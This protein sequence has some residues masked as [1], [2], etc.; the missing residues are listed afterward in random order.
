MKMFLKNKEV[1]KGREDLTDSIHQKL[2][3]FAGPSAHKV[4]EKTQF[5]LSVRAIKSITSK[6]FDPFRNLIK[7]ND[8]PETED[9][10]ATHSAFRV[11]SNISIL[12]SL[13]FLANQV[14]EKINPIY[15]SHKPKV[16]HRKNE[17]KVNSV[18]GSVINH[19]QLHIPL[20]DFDAE[21]EPLFTHP[22]GKRTFSRMEDEE[23]ALKQIAAN[24]VGA[25]SFLLKPF[26][27]IS[28]P[29]QSL[30]PLLRVAY[31]SRDTT[32]KFNPIRNATFTGEYYTTIE[33]LVSRSM[34]PVDEEGFPLYNFDLS[35]LKK[36]LGIDTEN[37]YKRFSDLAYQQ[38]E[39]KQRELIKERG[40]ALGEGD[41]IES[42]GFI[43]EAI[44]D[45]LREFSKEVVGL[46]DA[47]EA[48]S[49]F[50]SD[51]SSKILRQSVTGSVF[52]QLNI[53]TPFLFGAANIKMHNIDERRA[54]EQQLIKSKP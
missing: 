47:I 29:K 19:M 12:P 40:P 51:L 23:F 8:I 30:R 52:S 21:L 45:G 41:V 37:I 15:I 49:A 32:S 17:D 4:M 2:D 20:P 27:S 50:T 28:A 31:P 43:D 3:E 5:N 42:L 38:E 39:I 1:Q 54:E 36:R 14:T 44:N 33:P 16:K 10:I 24:A 34:Q 7:H 6:S 18:L 48:S 26:K 22:S 11:L 25:D 46:N 53:L 13:D 9:Q 35:V